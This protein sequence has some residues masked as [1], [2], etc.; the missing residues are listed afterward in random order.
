MKKFLFLFFMLGM[1]TSSAANNDD[2]ESMVETLLSKMTLEE[3]VRLS[4]AQSKFSSP[5]VARLGVPE[6]YCV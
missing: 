2:I 1:L 5:G 3:K 4:Y 6:L